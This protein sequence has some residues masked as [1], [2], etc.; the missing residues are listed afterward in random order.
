[1]VHEEWLEEDDIVI[2]KQHYEDLIKTI[3]ILLKIQYQQKTKR[4]KR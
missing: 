1:M 4:N 2:K 3:K